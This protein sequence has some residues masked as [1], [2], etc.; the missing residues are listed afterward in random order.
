MH[1]NRHLG[2]DQPDELDALPRIHGDHEQGHA[3]GGDGG[4]AEV[5][6]HEVDVRVAFGDLEEVGDEE[7]VAGDVD[8]VG[9]VEVWGG[10]GGEAA[11]FEHPAVCG[12]DLCGQQFHQRP[13]HL[14][15]FTL[16]P[17]CASALSLPI[18]ECTKAEKNQRQKKQNQNSQ[19]PTNHSPSPPR[20]R[21]PAGRVSPACPSP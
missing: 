3:G 5:D 7:G 18:D 11:E 13:V 1:R 14:L 16:P 9:G 10:R 12:G 20:P 8:A 4:A 2:R 19:P 15:T 21:A 6:E 17:P